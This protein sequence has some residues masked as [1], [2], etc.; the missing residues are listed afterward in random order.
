M[1]TFD[2]S[3]DI[4]GAFLSSMVVAV[5]CVQCKQSTPVT[6]SL[7]EA[8]LLWRHRGHL[9]D[10]SVDLFVR[11]RDTNRVSEMRLCLVPLEIQIFAIN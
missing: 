4:T 7:H 2:A 8:C 10:V 1:P 5:H 6:G 3:A 11:D 9:G